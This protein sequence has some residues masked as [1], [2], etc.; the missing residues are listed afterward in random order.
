MAAQA[1]HH[2][3]LLRLLGIIQELSE[4]LNQNRALSISLHN[5]ADNVKAQAVHSQTGFVLRRFN[6]DKPKEEYE[7]ELEHMNAALTSENMSLLH[8]NKQLLSLI[9]E[10]EQTLENVMSAFRTHARDVQEREL[11]LIKE[12]ELKL[13]ERESENGKRDLGITSQQSAGIARISQTLRLL[14]RELNGE[15]ASPIPQTEED[16]PL[17]ALTALDN[18]DDDSEMHEVDIMD[19]HALERECEL[20]RLVKENLMLRRLLG[21]DV[22]DGTSPTVPEMRHPEPVRPS[23][24][25]LASRK[26]PRGGAPSPMGGPGSHTAYMDRMKQLMRMSA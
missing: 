4:S 20:A 9:K 14:M 12:Y 13:L 24:S 18:D 11:A 7:S 15:G 16:S 2:L 22:H 26:P 21:E 19:D 25:M 5:V 3:D 17:V 10:Y 8:D 23:S 1:V 6:L